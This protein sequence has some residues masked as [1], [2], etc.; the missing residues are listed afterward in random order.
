MSSLAWAK[1]DRANSLLA[2]RSNI[3]FTTLSITL[4]AHVATTHHVQG[5][6]NITFDGLSRNVPPG[7]LGLDPAL[8]YKADA[9]TQLLE[10]LRLC[11]P[12]A[13]LV[14]IDDHLLLLQSCQ[15]L[16]YSIS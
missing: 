8:M 3:V 16:L 2:C 5:V 6:E 14:D 11:D 1:D 7:R 4:E 12:A 9:D 13:T 10:F 15:M